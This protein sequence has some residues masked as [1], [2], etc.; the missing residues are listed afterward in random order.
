MTISAFFL[1]TLTRLRKPTSSNG[2]QVSSLSASSTAVICLAVA[3]SAR[4]CRLMISASTMSGHLGQVLAR[5]LRHAAQRD[6]ALLGFDHAGGS[7]SYEQ[8]VVAGT[9]GEEELPNGHAFA[10]VAIELGVVLEDPPGG[11]KQRVDPLACALLR[12]KGH[13]LELQRRWR[14]LRRAARSL[15]DDGRRRQITRDGRRPSDRALPQ[16]IDNP[17]SVEPKRLTKT[18]AGETPAQR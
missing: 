12:R 4:P 5:L 9:V 3:A 11:P 14:R 7:A 16:G 2:W 8:Q 6:A 13:R 18:H 17:T 10:G 15:R 1:R